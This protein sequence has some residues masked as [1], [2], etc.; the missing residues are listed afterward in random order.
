[1]D[2]KGHLI[3]TQSNNLV[4]PFTRLTIGYLALCCYFIPGTVYAFPPDLFGYRQSQQA[5]ISVFSQWVQV[6]ERH[7]LE[8]VAEGNCQARTFNRCHLK[9]WHAF[10]DRIRTLPLNRQ[11]EKINQYA[12]NRPYILDIEN[13][14]LDDYWAV[15]RELLY[16]GGD[17]EDYAI[18][19]LFSLRW[20]GFP[21][22][23]LRIVVLQDTN[24]RVPHAVLAVSRNKN[25]YILDNQTE[26]V[27]LH[28]QI[29]H[30]S[31]VYS[32]NEKHWWIHTP[33]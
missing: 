3:V 13:Y 20:L 30:Y 33:N 14:G 12:N 11:L 16:N 18:T 1:M 31:P 23:N 15:A 5:D 6:L 29:V 27:I 21:T 2:S 9:N 4:S 19:K 24:L 22:E 32:I 28:N 26:E 17:C 8:D 25:I 7:I 10:L